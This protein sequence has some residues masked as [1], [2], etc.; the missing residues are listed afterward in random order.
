M[1]V[2]GQSWMFPDADFDQNGALNGF[3]GNSC[4]LVLVVY[5]RV[6]NYNRYYFVNQVI[7]DVQN[8]HRDAID[9]VG[10]VCYP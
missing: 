1:D 5:R 3:N 9:C 4:S 6:H 2:R 10:S 8:Y 7:Q